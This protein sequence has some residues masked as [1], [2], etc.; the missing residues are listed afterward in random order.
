MALTLKVPM[1]GGKKA[2][3]AVI[4]AEARAT[5][6]IQFVELYPQEDCICIHDLPL[7]W[8]DHYQ[9]HPDGSV[10]LSIGAPLPKLR[11]A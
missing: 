10:V 2:A 5:G 6:R 1:N 3:L 4:Q 11:E 7:F 9:V 8:E